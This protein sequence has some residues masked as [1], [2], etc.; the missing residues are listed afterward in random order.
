MKLVFATNNQHKLEEIR[1]ILQ[2][3]FEIVSLNEIVCHTDIPETG[4]TLEENALIKARYVFDNYGLDCFA[5]D[6][7]LEVEALNGEPGVYSARYAGGNGHDS[8]ANMQK[9]LQKMADK[10]HRKA[11]F[12]TVIALITSQQ[13][14]TQ[15]PSHQTDFQQPHIFEGIVNGHIAYEK[16]GHEGF[17]YDPIFIPEGYDKSFAE[18]GIEVKNNIS[19]RARAV[20]KL[21][22]WLLQKK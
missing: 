21:A 5:D 19:H 3:K 18:L 17:G 14:A 13:M 16:S 6:T 20:Q 7:G 22:N 1:K 8:E 4:S 9:L 2:P 10:I 11:R 15:N 12:R